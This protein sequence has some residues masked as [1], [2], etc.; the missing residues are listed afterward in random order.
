MPQDIYITSYGIISGIGHN[1]EETLSALLQL[2]SGVGKISNLNT[3]HTDIP[4][5]EV[6]LTD[7][8]M[9]DILGIPGEE[10]ITRVSLLGIWAAREAY[11]KACLSEARALGLKIGFINGTTVGGMEKSEE[12]Y[13]EFID[14][15]ST[16]YSGYISAHD[17][18]A[19][20]EVIADSLDRFDFVSTTSTACS[21]ALNSLIL[22]ANLVKAGI[23]DCVI[24][25]GTECLSKFHVNGFNTLMILDRQQ[26]R[27]FDA[28]R[29]GLNLGEGAAYLVIENQKSLEKKG[30]KPIAKLAGWG[31]ACDAFHQTASS[32][33]GIGAV[34]A[35]RQALRMS[36]LSPSDIDYINAHGTGTQNNDESEGAAVMTVFGESIP[37][38]SSTK[39][40]TGHT[41]SAAGAVES[42]ISLLAMENRFLPPNL[43]FE[44]KMESLTFEPVKELRKG[45]DIHHILNNSFGFGGNSSAVIFSKIA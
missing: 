20:T 26:C 5:A 34:L 8:E 9:K 17:C 39:S 27:P 37:P 43:L 1:A 44:K 16:L 22:G 6:R 25:G 31:N 3:R 41:T 21:S 12:Y 19:C 7:E 2:K 4:C 29:A 15:D 38:L 36:R 30:T 32:P 45:I 42:V 28:E 11:E 18:G 23:L 35:I 14:P 24:A 40:Y 33:D 10:I 13:K